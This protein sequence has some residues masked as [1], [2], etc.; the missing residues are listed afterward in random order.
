MR[1]DAGGRG[2]VYIHVHC[3]IDYEYYYYYPSRVRVHLEPISLKTQA[4]N[5]PRCRVAWPRV[6]TC[7]LYNMHNNIII[8]IPVECVY[9]SSRS[10]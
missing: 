4:R 5:T 1:R 9:I 8:I 10:L 7:T 6:Y 2:R 3:T